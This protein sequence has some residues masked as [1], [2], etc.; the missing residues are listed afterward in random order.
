MGYAIASTMIK[1]MTPQQQQQ[2]DR[3]LELQRAT[4]LGVQTIADHM[5]QIATSGVVLTQDRWDE[6]IASWERANKQ[7]QDVGAALTKAHGL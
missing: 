5:G 4:R 1:R 7:M 2:I 3:L 6:L